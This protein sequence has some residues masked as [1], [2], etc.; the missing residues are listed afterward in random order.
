MR[1][2]RGTENRFQCCSSGVFSSARRKTFDSL[3]CT[4]DLGRVWNF[5]SGPMRILNLRFL[6]RNC[7]W[8][9]AMLVGC[10]C[11]FRGSAKPPIRFT[12]RVVCA[13]QPPGGFPGRR[14][15]GPL[16]GEE[17][18]RCNVHHRFSLAL[19][20]AGRMFVNGRKDGRRTK[21]FPHTLLWTTFL[22]A[23]VSMCAHASVCE[24]TCYL[25]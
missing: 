8:Q 15:S 10:V 13:N 3:L 14:A 19:R 12:F 2:Y 22:S 5:S 4:M 20:S 17:L 7:K 1:C 6:I 9:C 23:C 18:D 11:R 21:D 16:S 24:R 25:F